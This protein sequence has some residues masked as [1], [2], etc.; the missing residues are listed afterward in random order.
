MSPGLRHELSGTAGESLYFKVP[1]NEEVEYYLWAI[2]L[3]VGTGDANLYVRQ[4]YEP[5]T[6]QSDCSPHKSAEG[7]LIC[8]FHCR[9]GGTFWV[10][11]HGVSDFD[12]YTMSMEMIQVPPDGES[13]PENGF[14]NGR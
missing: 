3:Q 7:F 14:H 6:T 4:T 5:S 1:L 11:V 13:C 8:Y 12:G 9:P 10:L 2:Y